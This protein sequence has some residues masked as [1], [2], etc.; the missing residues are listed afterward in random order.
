MYWVLLICVILIIVLAIA[1]IIIMLKKHKT[2]E[3][4]SIV[5]IAESRQKLSFRAIWIAVLSIALV[6]AIVCVTWQIGKLNKTLQSI[7][8]KLSGV[9]NNLSGIN[10]TMSDMDKNLDYIFQVLRNR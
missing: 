7:D 4:D 10:V 1:T 8:E 5:S 2:T 3:N 6:L 9:N